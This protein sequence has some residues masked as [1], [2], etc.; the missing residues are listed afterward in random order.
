MRERRRRGAPAATLDSS[1]AAV[2]VPASVDV[3]GQVMSAQ[4]N[5]VRV[6]ADYPLPAAAEASCA[7]RDTGGERPAELLCTVR[8]LLKKMERRVLVGDR[9]RVTA[10]DWGDRSGTVEEVLP[11]RSELP[12]PRVA[13]VDQV[14]MVFALA[15][16]AWE[17]RG[18]TR[19]LVAAE[20]GRLP[21]AV[22]LNKVD[23]V[24]P[25]E[26]DAVVAQVESWGYE[27]IPVSAASGAGL[28]ALAEA[29]AGRVSVL[30]GPSGVGKS[31]LI[32]TLTLRAAGAR[33][34]GDGAGSRELRAAAQGDG[35]VGSGAWLGAADAAA[36]GLQAI[37]EVS[38]RDGRGKHTTRHV[39]LLQVG[40][41]RLADTPGFNQPSF[42]ALMPADLPDCFPEIRERLGSCAFGNC[43]HLAEPGCAV[44]EGWS[45][46]AWYA[47]LAEEV[48]AADDLARW[49]AT[50]KKRRE[51]TVMA[52]EGASYVSQSTEQAY[53]ETDPADRGSGKGEIQL[54]YQAMAH[55]ELEGALA[56]YAAIEKRIGRDKLVGK[57]RELALTIAESLLA[58]DK[59][60][61]ALRK[62]EAV[63]R[64]K[65]QA[66]L[67]KED[68]TSCGD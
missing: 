62:G 34:R 14:L 53:L 68:L 38:E 50:G 41:G 56:R 67:Q 63:E 65:R 31:S 57:S 2:T 51:G 26:A 21:V 12:D 45:R 59:L 11:R 29:L 19:F 64:D 61:A 52:L 46:H 10:V 40:D 37:G 4:A 42:D 48:R 20:A 25:A 39:S 22:V 23:L 3:Y 60:E 16:P 32:N 58:R 43:A 47:E 55:R 13:N 5:F 66:G 8:G 9:V 24:P 33:G 49:R 30:A 17:P 35:A 6:H 27:A 54:R 18:A 7:Q 1:G 36:L 44:R 28:P 15:R